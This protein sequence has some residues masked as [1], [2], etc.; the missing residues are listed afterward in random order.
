[1][2][3]GDGNVYIRLQL[4]TVLHE[5]KL[6]LWSWVCDS[7]HT[8]ANRKWLFFFAAHASCNLERISIGTENIDSFKQNA[9]VEQSLHSLQTINVRVR[10]ESEFYFRTEC[11]RT[12]VA[13]CVSVLDVGWLFSVRN[14]CMQ[15][16]R[17]FFEISHSIGASQCA[18]CSSVRITK[19]E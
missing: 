19:I 17:N 10:R 18:L 3:R 9:F 2:W 8:C 13:R 6:N 5:L 16:F 15:L 12:V 4:S 1:M 7:G 11:A 14:H